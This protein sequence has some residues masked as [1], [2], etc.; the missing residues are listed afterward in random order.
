MSEYS[1]LLRRIHSLMK[2][3]DAPSAEVMG[4]LIQAYYA[5][6]GN[7]V[8]GSLHIVLDDYNTKDESVIWASGYASGAGDEAGYGIAELLLR[9]P[10]DER[11]SVIP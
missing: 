8:G 1:R 2:S 7:G 5:L 9:F 10:E 4:E 11:E 6:D 3:H